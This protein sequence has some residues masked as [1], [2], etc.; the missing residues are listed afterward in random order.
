MVP[1]PGKRTIQVVIKN[2]DG[3]LFEGVG[4]A[5]TSINEKGI[6][7]VLPLHENFISVV[8]D[9]IRIYKT[10]GK[11]QDV[12]IATGVLRVT[13]NRVNVYVGFGA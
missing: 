11:S 13:Q 10:D 4:K 1:D 2:K 9:F 3:V 6:F 7:D 12:K 8:R 5:L